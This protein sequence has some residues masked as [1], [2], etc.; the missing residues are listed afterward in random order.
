MLRCELQEASFRGATLERCEAVKC[1]FNRADLFW[2]TLE[3]FRSADCVM[4]GARMPE[5]SAIKYTPRGIAIP[6]ILEKPLFRV[7]STPEE[8]KQWLAAAAEAERFS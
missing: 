1:L 2:S 4:D 6:S 3:D 7:S 8:R 5:Q